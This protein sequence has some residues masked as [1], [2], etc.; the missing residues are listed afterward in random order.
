MVFDDTRNDSESGG[1]NKPPGSV[2]RLFLSVVSPET[3]FL[4]VSVCNKYFNQSVKFLYR[5]WNFL[6][7]DTKFIVELYIFYY[8]M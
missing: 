5:E 6:F 7:L 8:D 2:P 3:E 1:A 4:S